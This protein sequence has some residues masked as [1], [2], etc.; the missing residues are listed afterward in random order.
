MGGDDGGATVGKVVGALR[1]RPVCVCVC[2]QD[3]RW[4]RPCLTPLRLVPSEYPSQPPALSH[5]LVLFLVF[6]S[7]IV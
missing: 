7:S 2:W 1:A 6:S 4:Q 3:V 5:N